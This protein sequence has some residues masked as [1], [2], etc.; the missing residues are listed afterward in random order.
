MLSY[1]TLYK[2]LISLLLLLLTAFSVSKKQSGPEDKVTKTLREYNRK[3]PQQKVYIHT[4]RSRYETGDYL[5][6]KAY[7]LDDATHNF[8]TISTNLYV[9]LVNYKGEV[10]KTRVLKIKNGTA[11]GDFKLQDTIPKGYYRI[12]AYTNW[13]RNFGESFYFM[14]RIKINNPDLKYYKYRDRRLAKKHIRR[15]DNIDVTFFPEGGTYVKGV[16]TRIGIKAVNYSGEGVNFSGKII[17]EDGNTVTDIGT[18]YAGMG[19]FKITPK[20][21]T[22]YHAKIVYENGDEDEIDLP[23]PKDN[24]VVLNVS[25]S[26]DEYRITVKSNKKPSGKGNTNQMLLTGLVRNELYYTKTFPRNKKEVTIT[27]S[28]NT[29]PHGIVY[30][31]LF[32]RWNRPKC[33][34]LVFNRKKDPYRI[35]K[36]NISAKG[37]N[38]TQIDFNMS[39]NADHLHNTSLSASVIR[40]ND[41]LKTPKNAGIKPYLLLSSDL[42]GKIENPGWYFKK[43]TPKRRRA[44]DNLLLTQGWRRFDWSKVLNKELEPISHHVEQKLEIRGKITRSLIKFPYKG[45]SVKL[46]VLNKFNDRYKTKSNEDGLFS[47]TNLDYSDTLDMLIKARKPNGRKNVLVKLD[48]SNPQKAPYSIFNPAEL[49]A[50]FKTRTH[51]AKNY[52][53]RKKNE[54]ALHN[55][56]DHVIDFEKFHNS[57]YSNIMDALKGRVPGL[58]VGENHNTIRGI[59]SLNLSNEPLYLVDGV[60][61]SR[62]SVESIPINNV[63]RVEILKNPSNTSIYGINGANGVIAIYTREGHKVTHGKTEFTMLGY[64]TKRKFYLPAFKNAEKEEIHY[65]NVKTLFWKPDIRPDSSGNFSLQF[66]TMDISGKFQIILE[67]VSA[68]AGAISERYK[69]NL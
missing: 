11:A 20:E 38:E 69:L 26:N 32:D 56:P 2:T 62:G 65:D 35:T 15:S 52:N 45:A 34:R 9:E 57:G 39:A 3:Y 60:Q 51:K 36:T 43:N 1:N 54:S 4:D 13:M 49:L 27:V 7:V 6:F 46:T 24:G 14:K 16:Q 44:L 63:E 28:D 30:F 19:S 66:K 42:K 58:T 40:A 21:D 53:E 61:V 41:S 48:E 12:R 25:H 18:P 29:F 55:I 64:Y 10:T 33:E 68:K 5:W 59:S 31:T 22:E 17:D 8:D 50:D 67:G 37:N 47:F 23:E